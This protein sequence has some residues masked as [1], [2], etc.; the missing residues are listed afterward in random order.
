VNRSG[1]G[2]VAPW[3]PR[4]RLMDEQRLRPGQIYLAG[5]FTQHLSHAD[6]PEQD[7]GAVA[8]EPGSKALICPD[9]RW[10]R[11][12]LAATSSLE[13]LGWTVFLPHR[14]VSAWGERDIAAGDV[15]RECL[16]AVLASDALI[17]FMGESFGTH[18]EVGAALGLGIPTV[19][20][21]SDASAESYFASG[22]AT[23]SFVG[24]LIVDALDDIPQAIE[25]GKF[26]EALDRA[27]AGRVSAPST[28]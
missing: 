5:P 3:V 11:T 18:V 1:T 15:A 22:V 10:R 23:S 24:E 12:L 9:S 20:V 4:T 13:D 19:V 21:R 7:G 27:S 2:R 16:E 25:S 17:A 26:H 8:S 14:D 28:L 6:S